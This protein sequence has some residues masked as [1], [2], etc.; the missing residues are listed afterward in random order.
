MSSAQF[1]CCLWVFLFCFFHSFII[2]DFQPTEDQITCLPCLL[3]DLTIGNPIYV[4]FVDGVRKHVGDYLPLVCHH[5]QR[6]AYDKM[7][8]VAAETALLALNFF[9]LQE[10]IVSYAFMCAPPPPTSPC[11]VFVFVCVWRGGGERWK[12]F[13]SFPSS[14]KG[15]SSSFY[16]S[17]SREY[18]SLFL[19]VSFALELFCS[20]LFQLLL[21]IK[22]L[23]QKKDLCS[24]LVILWKN[25][26]IFAHPQS[27]IA[28]SLFP[29]LQHEFQSPYEGFLR[30]GFCYFFLQIKL[31]TQLTHW[32]K[33]HS[34]I[35]F[36]G[37][38]WVGWRDLSLFASSVVYSVSAC[39]S[40]C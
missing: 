1:S 40:L 21:F 15:I 28:T 31:I 27:A 29:G 30:W 10:Q 20:G 33:Y 14:V 22:C 2:I 4:T 11:I 16:C 39:V 18:V 13:S 8:V 34:K 3:Q 36:R 5:L 26:F 17:Q 38:V 9:D 12:L 25:L 37:V 35:I 23:W 7:S 32:L 19:C 24:A 6:E